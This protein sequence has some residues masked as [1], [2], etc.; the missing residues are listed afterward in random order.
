MV[1]GIALS[2]FAI[3]GIVEGVRKKNRRLIVTSIIGQALILAVWIYF[4]MNPY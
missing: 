1:F 2:L 3:A 4:Y